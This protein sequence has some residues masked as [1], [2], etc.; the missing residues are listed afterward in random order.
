MQ[1]LTSTSELRDVVEKLQNLC[2]ARATGGS[3]D[4]SYELLRTQLL[5]SPITKNVV[6]RFIRNCRDSFQFWQF[7]K[8]EY[9]SYAERR[10]FIWKEFRQLLEQLESGDRSPSDD[11]VTGAL[12][13]LKSEYVQLIWQRALERRVSEPEGAITLARTLLESVCK[14]ILDAAGEEYANDADLPR[15]FR[16]TS[17]KLSIAPS[18]HSVPVFK[19]ILGGCTAVVE[20]LGSLRNRI[21]DAH[22]QGVRP[23]KPAPRHAELAVNLAGTMAMFLVSTW[24]NQQEASTQSTN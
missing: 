22:G 12:P 8:Y 4:T 16:L 3:D 17:E 6:P 10:Q 7:I 11:A 24:L 18:Q 21:G 20:G 2:I 19:Q 13:E 15:L 14:H 5:S 1:T 23:V 9:S